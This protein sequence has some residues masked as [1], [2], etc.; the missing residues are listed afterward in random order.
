M[1]SQSTGLEH[2]RRIAEEQRRGRH[3]RSSAAGGSGSIPPAASPPAAGNQPP[4]RRPKRLRAAI[5]LLSIAAIFALLGVVARFDPAPLR[6]VVYF[7]WL[8][9][10]A[11]LL[12]LVAGQLHYRF[13]FRRAPEKFWALILQITTTGKEQQRVNE[14][15][16][17]VRGYQLEIPYEIWVVTEPGQN[18]SYPQADWVLT[19][20][21]TFTARAHKKARALCYSARVR[22]EYGL[23]TSDI[24]ILYNDDDVLP[25]KGYIEKAFA[26]D[27]DICEGITAPRAFYGGFRPFGHFLSSHADDMRTRG[28]LIYCSV[29]QGILGKPLHV[30]GEGL[31]VTG[32]CERIVGWNRPV[33]ASEDLTFGQ[34]AA[35]MGMRWGWFHDYVELTSPWSVREFLIQRKRWF[36]G[37]VHAITH[38][39]V[40]PLSRAIPIAMKWMFGATTVIISVTGLALKFT[41]HLPRQSPIYDVSK[42]AILTWLTIFV[43]CG[44]ID[45]SSRTH[46]RNDDSRLLNA[47]AAVL[48]SPVSSFISVA[49]IA[50]SLAQGNPRTFEVIRKTRQL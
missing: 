27:Y 22:K 32:A 37:N 17:S 40:L 35:K 20:P 43:T 4:R 48:M 16:S 13:G 15:I 23:D 44:W 36:W 2:L 34:N 3:R 45:A 47:L 14:I 33:F 42:L 10:L 24:K 19:V 50:I 9:P 41:G 21:A 46:R 28:C 26:A 38:R 31:T 12:L 6:G 39:D 25:T 18:D 30:H 8:V 1:G 5:V 49:V 11:E 29:F 7:V